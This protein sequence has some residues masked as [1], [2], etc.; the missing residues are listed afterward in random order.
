ME[1]TD[2][3]GVVY[4]G[5]IP[6]K[7]TPSHLKGLLARFA[8]VDRIYLEPY[9][10]SKGKDQSFSEGWIEFLDKKDA[11]SAALLLNGQPMTQGKKKYYSQDLWCLKYLSGFRWTHLTEKL[12]YERAIKEQ[13]L[14]TELAQSKR[15]NSLFM[16]QVERGKMIDKIHKKKGKPAVSAEE[17]FE[18]IKRKFKQ[19]KIITP[20]QPKD[21]Q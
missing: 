17:S 18:T 3:R 21:E 12:A 9:S 15:E 13:K 5:K 11:K 6:P 14:Q 7:M 20:V 19:R 1:E 4:I 10:N 8:P 2:N 16:R